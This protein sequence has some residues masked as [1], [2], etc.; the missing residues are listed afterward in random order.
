MR[1]FINEIRFVIKYSLISDV[2]FGKS[3]RYFEIS[4]HILSP[5]I[6]ANNIDNFVNYL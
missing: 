5:V 1:C 3:Y 2:I 6:K 4:T